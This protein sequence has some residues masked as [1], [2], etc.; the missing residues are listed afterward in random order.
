MK[1]GTKHIVFLCSRLDLPG[2]IEKS[3][4]QTANALFQKGYAIS[5]LNFDNEPG[6]F[7]P[8]L[9]GIQHIH[10]NLSFGIGESGTKVSRKLTFIND[11]KKLRR[12]IQILNPS[13]VIATEYPFSIAGTLAG[14]QKRAKLISWEHHHLFELKKNWFWSL[15]FRYTY[16]KLDA[17]VCLNPDEKKLFTSY[18]KNIVTIPNFIHTHTQYSSL[19]NKT[20]L[21]VGRLTSVKGTDLL[22]ETAKYVFAQHKDWKWEIIGD[23]DM[24]ENLISF[25][26]KQGFEKNIELFAP[27]SHDLTEQYLDASIYICTSRHESFGMTLAEAMA[28]GV[29]CISFDCETGPRHIIKHDENGLLVKKENTK[30]LSVAIAK[31]ISDIDQRKKAG[32]KAR[33]SSNLFTEENIINKWEELFASLLT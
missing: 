5:I 19:E 20:L 10:L 23:G 17:I 4:I 16:P 22:I 8:L 31:L 2:G 24:K 14:I 7:F 21:T 11:I 6:T 32:I 15:L 1:E 25:I 27:T 12:K 28:A 33:T 9:T 30:E 29:P 13:I 3:I 18:N 26:K